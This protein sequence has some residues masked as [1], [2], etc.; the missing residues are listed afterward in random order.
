MPRIRKKTS[1]RG[2]LHQR[3]RIQKKVKE[4]HRKS[5]RETKRNPP[6]KS[7]PKDP[8]IPNAFPFKDQI[9]AEIADQRR[10]AVEDK[11]RRKEERKAAKTGQAEDGSDASGDE[12]NGGVFDGVLALNASAGKAP[13]KPL[14]APVEEE[15]AEAE[16][17]DAP[18]L[19]N[20]DLPNLKAV[21]DAADVVLQVLD[22]RDPMSAR[23]V[24][25]EEV[26]REGGKR[27]LFVLNKVDACPR[28]AVEAWATTLRK[29]HPTVLFRSA[30]ASLPA[31]AESVKGKGKER[32]DDAWGLDA[33]LAF[34]TQWAGEKKGETPFTVAVVG[35]TNVGKSS[36][37]NS[38]LRKAALQT[39]KLTATPSD[40]PTTTT[41]PQEVTLELEGKQVRFID[42]PGL[43]W[44]FVEDAS[45]EDIGRTRARDVLIRNR[46]HVE[47]MKDPSHV[48]S[49]LVSRANREDLMLLYNLP[50]FT[51]GDANS[52]L[53]GVARANGFIKRKGALDLTAASRLVLRDWSTGKFARYTT[54][55]TSSA[56][57]DPASPLAEIYAKDATILA[58]L[59]TRKEL[60]KTGGLV[61]LRAGVVDA[62][63]VTLDESYSVGS[64]SDGDEEDA[65]ELDDMDDED[66][67]AEDTD[68]EDEVDELDDDDDEDADDDA[69]E[70]EDEEEDEEE[71]P[72]SPR[73]KRKRTATKVPARPAKKVAFAAEPRDTR[74]ARAAAG[75]RGSAVA[76][77]KT[78]PSLKKAA[79]ES[80]AAP[81]AKKAK[82][83]AE[84]VV[85]KRVANSS[86]GS[87]KKAAAPAA[88]AGEEAYDFKQFF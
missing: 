86:A 87:K 55:P 27:V 88:K 1:K 28:E 65:A 42:T 81:A 23:S 82:T 14:A 46:G 37:V 34:L 5:K 35:V 31:P 33:T 50:I 17:E 73:G 2:T 16:E 70:D 19:V 61:K 66:L 83:R 29:E 7:K 21:L 51:E 25:L 74:Q 3:A 8:G 43:S 4:T 53:A 32:A 49:E 84:P 39:Y 80:A 52:F 45:E 24:H 76:A 36:V 15:E 9:L 22:A 38:L 44:Q 68:E 60:R 69:E 79:K 56:T 78:K 85:A 10:Q 62:R 47:R 64:E 6:K 71:L 54:P 58:R 41:H 13:R 57:S 26:A 48:L 59:A 67:D 20:P 40:A 12:D 18:I 63:R 11:Q 72:A 75:A 77:S 30:S